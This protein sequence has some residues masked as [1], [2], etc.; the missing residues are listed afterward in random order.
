MIP[1]GRCAGGVDLLAGMGGSAGR[2][3]GIAPGTCRGPARRGCPPKVAP[4][5]DSRQRR[6]ERGAQ[7]CTGGSLLVDR[8]ALGRRSRSRGARWCDGDARNDADA[9]RELE[10]CLG[11]RG[12]SGGSGDGRGD[13]SQ[14][15]DSCPGVSGA[16]IARPRI[17]AAAAGQCHEPHAA[18]AR[19]A[20]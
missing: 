7:R 4:P 11:L 17:G 13:R 2:V 9:H 14:R 19:R 8:A 5:V 1:R 15:R 6:R 18:R 16:A 3:P 12:N 20:C 10:R